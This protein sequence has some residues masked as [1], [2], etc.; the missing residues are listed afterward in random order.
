MILEHS[1]LRPAD[2]VRYF[3]D[4]CIALCNSALSEY[5]EDE[6][7]ICLRFDHLRRIAARGRPI[8]C[9]IVA[10]CFLSGILA[11]LWLLWE[12]LIEVVSVVGW[13]WSSWW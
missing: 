11:L 5:A 1:R 10:L 13:P 3:R 2:P 7:E 8:S 12:N 9:L 6:D 4:E